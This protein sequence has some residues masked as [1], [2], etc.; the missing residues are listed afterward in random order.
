LPIAER[1]TSMEKSLFPNEPQLKTYSREWAAAGRILSGLVLTPFAAK[2][3]YAFGMMRHLMESA[4]WSLMHKPPYECF[5]IAAYLLSC[6]AIE[7]F[8]RC[9]SGDDDEKSGATRRLKRGLKEIASIL[10]SKDDDS[11]VVVVT[12][13]KKYTIADCVALRNF[14]AH[15]GS[16]GAV[17]IDVELVDEVLKKV[18][19]AM[20][21]YWDRLMDPSDDN[22]RKD[23]AKAAVAPLFAGPGPD[24]ILV[25]DIYS[26]IEKGL[27]ISE[28]LMYR[29]AWQTYR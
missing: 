24:A 9:V 28:G 2:A 14:C 5:Y 19:Q 23:L 15:G 1:R 17:S 4:G 25:G 13:H 10:P 6:G 16:V 27:A 20:D 8:G 3:L 29:D 22:V 12:N 7:L 11:Q 18:S 21:K 26:H